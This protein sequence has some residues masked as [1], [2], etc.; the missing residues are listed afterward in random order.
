MT[1]NQKRNRAKPE[2][3]GSF[4]GEIYKWGESAV[5]R[6]HNPKLIGGKRAIA[7]LTNWLAELSEFNGRWDQA[8]ATYINEKGEGH[9]QIVNEDYFFEEDF[10]ED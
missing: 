2:L 1:E 8:V 4:T 9:F 3:I 5:Y 7:T 10:D 6:F